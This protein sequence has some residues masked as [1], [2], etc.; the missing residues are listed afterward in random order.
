MLQ[1]RVAI[2]R[3]Q[4]QLL[5]INANS[6]RRYA[7]DALTSCPPHAHGTLE[8]YDELFVAFNDA[9]E[10]ALHA[11]CS[12]V[13]Q[14]YLHPGRVCALTYELHPGNYVQEARA[15]KVRPVPSTRLAVILA[16]A[17]STLHALWCHVQMSMRALSPCSL[18]T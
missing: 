2:V 6:E 16:K 11:L 14:K 12:H 1:V 18:A 7:A 17:F 9:L 3:S 10:V 15:G 4:Q 13:A 8:M 5:V